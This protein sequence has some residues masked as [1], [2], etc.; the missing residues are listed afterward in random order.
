MPRPLIMSPGMET[1]RHLLAMA[2]TWID[3]GE[4]RY[5]APDRMV[6]HVEGIRKTKT[7]A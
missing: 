6:F 7:A 4:P 2:V 1:S 5:R 3:G